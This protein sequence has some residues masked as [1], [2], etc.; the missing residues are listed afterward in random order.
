MNSNRLIVDT[1]ARLRARGA[2]MTAARR[3]VLLALAGH[4]GHHTA[5][6]VASLVAELDPAVHR[7]SVY[8]GLE[9]LCSLGVVAHVHLGHGTT[10]YHLSEAPHLHAQCRVCGVLVDLPA[11]GLDAVADALASEHGF[12]LDP[13]H[14]ALSGTCYQCAPAVT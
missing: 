3:A 6:A 13:T 9:A 7:S 12:R 14:V 11:T 2:R 1:A 8:R 5:D 10:V 4:P